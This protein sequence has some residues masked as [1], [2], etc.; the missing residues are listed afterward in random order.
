MIQGIIISNK[1]DI[2]DYSLLRLL[3]A[4]KQKNINLKVITPDQFELVVTR[5]SG[6][7]L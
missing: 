7:I 3:E 6:L 5:C 4:S 1:K 2:T